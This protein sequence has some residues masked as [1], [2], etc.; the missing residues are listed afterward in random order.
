MFY[1]PLKN[2]YTPQHVSRGVSCFHIGRPCV[3]PSV[4]ST[5]GRPSAPR[6]RSITEVFID[7]FYC[8]FA[9]AFVP[10]MSRMG[11]LVGKFP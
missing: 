10:I 2:F 4:R 7:G 5:Y 9:Y 3:R 6:F 8:N 1:D 11:L